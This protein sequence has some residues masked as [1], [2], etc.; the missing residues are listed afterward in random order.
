MKEDKLR[1]ISKKATVICLPLAVLSFTVSFLLPLGTSW[2]VFFYIL[3]WLLTLT[4]IGGGAIWL[5]SAVEAW[6]KKG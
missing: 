4:A 1:K 6:V 2:F 5:I 3:A